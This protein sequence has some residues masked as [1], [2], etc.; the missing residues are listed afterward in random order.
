MK[1]YQIAG[2]VA[3]ELLPQLPAS[4]S[5]KKKR[6]YRLAIDSR[7]VAYESKND[8]LFCVED[9]PIEEAL[10]KALDW[11]HQKAICN[12]GTWIIP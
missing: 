8:N 4:I 3:R 1:S 11:L 10:E 5:Y 6:I 7:R 2:R 12:N 9:L